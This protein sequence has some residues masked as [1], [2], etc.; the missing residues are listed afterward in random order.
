MQSNIIKFAFYKMCV[1]MFFMVPIA[2]L[3]WQENGLSMTQIMILQSI[4]SILVVILEIPTGYFADVYG[5]RK[6]L[7]LGALMMAIAMFVYSISNGFWDFLIGEIFFA[8]AISLISGADSAF[9]YDSLR[10]LGREKEYQKV[11]GNIIFYGLIALAVSNIIGGLVG[12]INLRLPWQ[13]AIPFFSLA[14]LIAISMQEPRRYKAI[15]KKGY[16]L[17]ILRILKFSLVENQKLKWLIIYSGVIFG[18]NQS[19]LWTYQPYF[20]LGGVDILYFGFIFASFQLVAAFTSKYAYFLE[21]RIGQKFSLVMLVVLLAGSFLLMSNFVF[22]FSFSFAFLQQFVRGFR[23]VVIKDYINKIATSDIRATVL[24]V[25]SLGGRLIYAL[26]V[27]FVGWIVDVYSLLQA[28]FILGITSLI[29]GV[30]AL[31]FL[32]RV[33]VL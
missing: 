11:F 17:E 21:E 31:V 25:E 10:D 15:I 7:I 9:V 28:L 22:L 27:P 24:S 32:R 30:I 3:F 1:S 33:R 16:F 14:V 2:V 19:V 29:F 23:E 26:V 13:I 12:K 18:F 20:Q 6:S 8:L 5:R 4:F